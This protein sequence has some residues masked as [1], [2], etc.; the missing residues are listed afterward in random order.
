MKYKITVFHEML[1]VY[2]AISFLRGGCTSVLLLDLCMSG[3]YI[4][5]PRKELIARYTTNIL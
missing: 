2:R 1:A 4:Q 3:V 5:P